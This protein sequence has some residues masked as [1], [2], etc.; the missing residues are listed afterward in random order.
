LFDA[1]PEAVNLLARLPARWR[2]PQFDRAFK[3]TPELQKATASARKISFEWVSDTGRHVGSLVHSFLNRIAQDGVEQ[4]TSNRIVG[5]QPLISS[6]LLRLGVAR[7]DEPAA[8][9]QVI[10]ALTNTLGSERGRWILTKREEAYCEWA[11]SGLVGTR[12]ISGTVDRAFR[13]EKGRLWIVDFKT[14]E[15]EGSRLKD[16]LDEQQARY[17]S[18][19]QSYAALLTGMGM[20]PIV[21]GL[22]FPLLDAWREWEYEG[23]AVLTAH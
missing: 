4:W 13:D 3:W 9:S 8:T 2:L 23:E 11:I 18:Q 14:S 6:E 21:L 15:H 12:L 7:G 19:L 20:G 1:R 10:R 5:S 16:F 17:R 22:Y